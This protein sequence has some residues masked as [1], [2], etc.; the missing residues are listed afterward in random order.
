MA[1]VLDEDQGYGA[2]GGTAPGHGAGFNAGKHYGPFT[3][4]VWAAIIVGGGVAGLAIRH[5]QG[6]GSTP[7]NTAAVPETDANNPANYGYT[8]T[9]GPFAGGGTGSSTVSA[10]GTIAATTNTQWSQIALEELISQGTDPA[11]AQQAIGNFL[12]GEPLTAQQKSIISLAIRLAGSPPEGAPPIQDVTAPTPPVDGG[13]G[14]SPVSTPTPNPAQPVTAPPALN[15]TQQAWVGDVLTTIGLL[16]QGGQ[17]AQQNFSK[18]EFLH[19]TTNDPHLN[20]LVA[21]AYAVWLQQHG[22]PN[23]LIQ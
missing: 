15:T 1:D 13:S 14:Q 5:F 11:L 9:G 2:G 22:D 10:G 19:I 12:D 21:Y 17:V 7:T 20:G 4:P 18:A 6:S 16:N 3:L 23:H 8:A